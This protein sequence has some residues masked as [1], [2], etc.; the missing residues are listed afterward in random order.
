MRAGTALRNRATRAI[1]SRRTYDRLSVQH[2][3][4]AGIAVCIAVLGVQI[5][6]RFCA[7]VVYVGTGKVVIFV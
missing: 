3:V 6:A 7:A 5:V 1:I 2:A 4:G